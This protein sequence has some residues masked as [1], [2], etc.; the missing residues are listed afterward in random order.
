MKKLF[1]AIAITA[2]LSSAAFAQTS[3]ATPASAP[4]AVSASK[5]VISYAVDKHEFGTV[6]QGTPVSYVFSFK[7]TGK[8]PLVL[9][10]VTASC[11]C[12]TPEWPK[13]PVAPGASGSIKVTYNAANPGDF[14]K[15]VTVVSNAAAPTT[16]LTIHGEVKPAAAAANTATPAPAPKTAAAPKKS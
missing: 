12:T 10:S 2:G 8:E 13:E 9:S 16:V 14:T 4:A 5:A 6:P 15:T 7:N 3:V 1:F 11:G